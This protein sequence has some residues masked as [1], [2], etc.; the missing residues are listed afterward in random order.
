MKKIGLLVEGE[1]DEKLLEPLLRDTFG[2]ITRERSEKLPS[3]TFPF[4]P[5]GY[6]EISKNLRTLIRLYQ[7]PDERDRIGCGFFLIIHDSRKTEIVQKEVRRI[8]QDAP[9]F[10]AVY[11]LAIQETEAW[12]LGDIVHVNRYVFRVKPMPVLCRSPERE[13]DPKKVLT[14][15]FVAPST[16]VEYDRWNLECARLVAP[17]LR[18]TQVASRCP[19]GFGKLVRDLRNNQR[20]LKA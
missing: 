17:Y 14:D 12:V 8:L 13:T 2:S 9:D 1:I 4:P 3:V 7:H 15:I 20:L 16:D 6:G 5:N 10:P 18:H 11:G 19:R